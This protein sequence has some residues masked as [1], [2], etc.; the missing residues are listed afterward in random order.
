MKTVM[1]PSRASL[2]DFRGSSGH[3]WLVHQICFRIAPRQG[4]P[5]WM[6]LVRAS[7][8]LGDGRVVSVMLPTSIDPPRSRSPLGSTGPRPRGS[9]EASILDTSR[10]W[11]YQDP[12]DHCAAGSSFRCD[13]RSKTEG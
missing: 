4:N 13:F 5:H 8:M 6:N 10:D 11:R 1:V 7:L 9:P 2:R 12:S 3:D